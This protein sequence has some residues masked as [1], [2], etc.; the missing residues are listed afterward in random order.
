MNRENGA[1]RTATKNPLWGNIFRRKSNT[2]EDVL[3]TLRQVPLFSNMNDSEL[4]EF[5]KLIHQRHF[6][7]GET[8]FWEGEPGVGMYIIQHGAVAICKHSRNDVR[9][10]LVRLH[11]GEFFG[12]LALLD[13][14]PRSASAIAEENSRII[15]LFRP[16]LFGLLERKPRL[17]NKFLFQLALII[18]ERLKQ[19]NTEIQ[20]LRAQLERSEVVL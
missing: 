7:A 15:G 5:E 20:N 4:R 8:I 11:D 16:D 12:E 10:T 6:K 18:G 13:E 1:P 19:T 2:A 14:S 3:S 17:G 9:E